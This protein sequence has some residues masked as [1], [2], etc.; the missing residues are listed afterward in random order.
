MTKTI[1]FI[2]C[3]NFLTATFNAQ[4]QSYPETVI[5]K[6]FESLGNVGADETDTK[7]VTI[8]PDNSVETKM[9]ALV[10]FIRPDYMEN[11]TNNQL[12]IKVEM[13]RW[14][15]IGFNVKTSNAIQVTSALILT[16]YILEKN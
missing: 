12:K 2:I 10:R 4:E 15:N 11:F 16:T 3:I 8:T 6:I 9:L 7:I 1:L 13:Q 14:R 5:I